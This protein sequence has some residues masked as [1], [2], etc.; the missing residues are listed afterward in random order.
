MIRKYPSTRK[1]WCHLWIIWLIWS[2]MPKSFWRWRFASK[3]SILLFF[4]SFVHLPSTPTNF[5]ISSYLFLFF[6]S[7]DPFWCIWLFDTL[8]FGFWQKTR[9]KSGE[10]VRES[11]SDPE[12]DLQEPISHFEVQTGQFWEF[13][14]YHHWYDLPQHWDPLRILIITFSLDELTL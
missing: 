6:L 7:W 5:P 2:W 14:H 11:G 4:C 10:T 12:G 13:L 9:K 1:D 8:F 3:W